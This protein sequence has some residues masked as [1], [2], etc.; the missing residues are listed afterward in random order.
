MSHRTRLGARVR[1][2]ADP[3]DPT[4]RTRIS[5]NKYNRTTAAASPGPT[6]SAVKSRGS[7]FNSIRVPGR[8][9]VDLQRSAGLGERAA[10]QMLPID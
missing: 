3:V 8:I 6:P 7:P 2:R 5:E 10:S 1:F 4:S 9:L